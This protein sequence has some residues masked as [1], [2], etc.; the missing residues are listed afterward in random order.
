MFDACRQEKSQNY[1]VSCQSSKEKSIQDLLKK[2]INE[3]YLR[4]LL[5]SLIKDQFHEK[6]KKTQ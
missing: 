5:K 2:P 6:F 3:V 4:N 1:S